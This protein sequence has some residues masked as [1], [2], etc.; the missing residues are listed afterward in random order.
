MTESDSSD[1]S[2]FACD[3]PDCDRTFDTQRGATLHHSRTHKENGGRE[4]RTCPVCGDTFT[5][6]QSMPTRR[7]SNEC[8]Y[9]GGYNNV[10]RECAACGDGVTV[11]ENQAERTEN[12]FCDG[13]CFGEWKGESITAEKHPLWSG[14]SGAYRAL[15]N[16]HGDRNWKLLSE[17]IRQDADGCGLCGADRPLEVHHIVPIMRGGTNARWNLIPVCRPCH[18]TTEGFSRSLF[19]SI[20]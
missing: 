18:E 5:A 9:E 20:L 1:D 3:H 10:T 17:E 13:D 6:R 7:C 19:D 11:P 2:S 12:S 16:F 8:S 4:E 14:G 15:V